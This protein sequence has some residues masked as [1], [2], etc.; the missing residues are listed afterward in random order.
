MLACCQQGGGRPQALSPGICWGLIPGKPGGA[1]TDFSGD[2]PRSGFC[3]STELELLGF[4]CGKRIFQQVTA[5]KE[6]ARMGQLTSSLMPTGWEVTQGIT[7]GHRTVPAVV[8]RG[9]S[10]MREG[11]EGS[12][13]LWPGK[14]VD[15]CLCCLPSREASSP[16]LAPAYHNPDVEGD[17]ERQVGP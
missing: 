12:R 16:K 14:Q 13:G 15:H 9:L 10:L 6:G 8:D 3:A 7:G 4:P 2:Y 11:L 5:L 17:A 1:V